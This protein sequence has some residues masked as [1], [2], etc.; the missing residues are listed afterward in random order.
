MSSATKP[1]YIQFTMRWNRRKLNLL[2]S[3]SLISWKQLQIHI[4]T[5]EFV[6]RW[7][8]SANVCSTFVTSQDN[9][10]DCRRAAGYSHSKS[11][12]FSP[13]P[14]RRSGFCPGGSGWPVGPD[15]RGSPGAKTDPV[16]LKHIEVLIYFIEV[17]T[18]KPVSRLFV[19]AFHLN[20]K[21]WRMFEKPRIKCVN[22]R[23]ESDCGCSFLSVLHTV[24]IETDSSCT[25]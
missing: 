21:Y 22:T 19:L 24:L 25:E 3:G 11:P 14:W 20:Y 18:A 7:W 8:V 10:D 6:V 4:L 23:K 9:K 5:Q 16:M 17:K 12:P 2:H 13:L 15:H 1:K